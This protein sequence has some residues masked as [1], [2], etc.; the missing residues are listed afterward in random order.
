MQLKSLEPESCQDSYNKLLDSLTTTTDVF[1]DP[2]ILEGHDHVYFCDLGHVCERLEQFRKTFH[3]VQPCYPVECNDTKHLLTL[4]ANS[5]VSFSCSNKQNVKSVCDVGGA[6]SAMFGSASVQKSHLKY[7]MESGIQVMTFQN[8]LDLK[9]LAALPLSSTC[10][11]IVQFNWD[12]LEL[13]TLE[14]QTQQMKKLVKT[15]QK[16]QM[17]LVG[18]S[19]GRMPETMKQ[20]M[21]MVMESAI[22]VLSF[23]EAL[24][25]PI[26][27]LDLGDI[28]TLA[29]TPQGLVTSKDTDT[30]S[31]GLNDQVFTR[32]PSLMVLADVGSFLARSAFSLMVTVTG[33][34]TMDSTADGAFSDEF[35]GQK[36]DGCVYIND[37]VYGSFSKNLQLVTPTSA[38]PKLLATNSNLGTLDSPGESL[39]S[40]DEMVVCVRGKSGDVEDVLSSCC[41]LSKSLQMGDKLLF[42]DMGDYQCIA[43]TAIGN[44]ETPPAEHTFINVDQIEI[45]KRLKRKTFTFKS[46]F[47]DNGGRLACQDLDT[48]LAR[49]T[50]GGLCFTGCVEDL[51]HSDYDVIFENMALLEQ[52]HLSTQ[53]YGISEDMFA[54]DGEPEDLTLLEQMG[55][56]QGPFA[57]I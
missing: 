1:S 37:S 3:K 42:E 33:L 55:Y 17:Q 40:D 39:S 13:L 32:W 19:L 23:M 38:N 49:Q 53:Q 22:S 24:G 7:S 20:D 27:I 52:T 8:E 9:K 11:F 18:V 36:V 6:E 10:R 2:A 44:G 51:T 56:N 4:L 16:K 31:C 50:N 29:M 43:R 21:E 26:N 45:A 34:T 15:A 14:A 30:I 25:F 35:Y 54:V 47:M 48:H 46:S 5:G 41:P 57:F 28:C 12:S